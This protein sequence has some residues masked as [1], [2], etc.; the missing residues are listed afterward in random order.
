M[1]PHYRP[2]QTVCLTPRSH[3]STSRHLHASTSFSFSRLNFTTLRVHTFALALAPPHICVCATLLFQQ[4]MLP[5]LY[6]IKPPGLEA[7]VYLPHHASTLQHLPFSSPSRFRA[8]TLSRIRAFATPNLC[9]FAPCASVHFEFHASTARPSRT[10]QAVTTNQ[11][12]SATRATC[13]GRETRANRANR[14]N[15]TVRTDHAVRAARAIRSTWAAWAARAARAA[16]VSAAAPAAFCAPAG[17]AGCSSSGHFT[18][19]FAYSTHHELARRM[20][21]FLRFLM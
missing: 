4:Y 8:S 11:T 13:S 12:A 10:S 3:R 18:R 16:R 6:S 15:R 20:S 2:S 14:A 21:L 9:A 17:R 19:T 7:S 1:P 5:H